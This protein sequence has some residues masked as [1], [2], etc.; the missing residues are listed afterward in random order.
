MSPVVEGK[1][2]ELEAVCARRGVSRLAVFGSAVRGDFD[3][4]KSDIDILVEFQPMSPGQHAEA[5]F[6]LQ[7]DLERLFGK[8]V[9][10]VEPGP[11]RNPYFRQAVDET[12][13]V[14][15]EAS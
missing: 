15:Y 1:T 5:Y 14:L 6:G 9:D 12:S 2:A 3:A 7:E 11:I 4:S 13:V 8:Q 10:L